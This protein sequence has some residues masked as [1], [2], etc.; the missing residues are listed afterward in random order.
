[1][2]ANCPPPTTATTGPMG[3][4]RNGGYPRLVTSSP[5]AAPNETPR[6]VPM[7]RDRAR[8]WAWFSEMMRFGTVG[9]I[10]FV[11]DTGLFNLL[12]FGPGELLGH[13]PLTAKVV[14]VTVAVLVAWLGNR[15]WT[16]AAKRSRET[17]AAR[18]RELMQFALVNVAGMA[19]GV[20]CLA[21]SHYLLGFT[22]PLADNISANGVGLV[23]GT[24]FRY[25][26]YRYWVFTSVTDADAEQ[27]DIPAAARAPQADLPR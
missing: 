1:M 19:I 18:S 8:L 16:F 22:S 10:A 24:I 13:K 7:W 9:L 20:G 2:R 3:V 27:A 15:Y 21:V 25:L 11:V 14:S 4:Q 6:A 5:S 23:L 17:A 26:A 12:R